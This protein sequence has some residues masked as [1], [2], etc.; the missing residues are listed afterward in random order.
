MPFTHPYRT[1]SL[2]CC[3][4]IDLLKETGRWREGK[5]LAAHE[6]R[7]IGTYT[8]CISFDKECWRIDSLEIEGDHVIGRMI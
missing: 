4:L 5:V 7:S 3:Q 2:S 6:Q 8:D 1:D